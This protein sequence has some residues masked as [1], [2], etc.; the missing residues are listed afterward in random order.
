MQGLRGTLAGHGRK[1]VKLASFMRDNKAGFGLVENG[2]AFDIKP[3]AGSRSL[4]DFLADPRE[5][6]R[7]AAD[8]DPV[9]LSGLRWLPPVP[10]PPRIFCVGRNFR[11]GIEK[12][13]LE[14]PDYPILFVRS[15][16]AQVGHGENIVRPRV[17]DQFDFEGEVCVVIGLA[18]RH[19]SP[20]R[21]LAHVA[22]YTCFNDGSVRDYQ[23]HTSQ[24][25]P[26]KNFWKSGAAGPWLV[27]ADEIQD[28]ARLEIETRVNDEVVQ[29]GSMDDLVFSVGNVISYLSKIAPLQPGDHIAMGTPFGAGVNQDPPR[30]L[31]PGDDV[32]VR[33]TRIG[34]LTNT[35][36]DEVDAP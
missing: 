7:L 18:G 33:V 13:G 27:T 31:E 25:T 6:A 4:V 28:P 19:L 16:A 8:V 3:L 26:G 29:S 1:P 23:R 2:A 20:E 9:P 5:A 32:S 36:I 17:S 35:V 30:W 11:S 10:V 21:A 15:P 34:A 24:D 22:G 14:I 12:A